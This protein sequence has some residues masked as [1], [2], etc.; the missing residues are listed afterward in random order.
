MIKKAAHLDGFSFMRKHIY[1][2]H[3]GQS[4]QFM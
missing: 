2:F 4:A 1:M 3:M